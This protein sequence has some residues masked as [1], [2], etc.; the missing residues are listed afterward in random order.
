MTYPSSPGFGRQ[1]RNSSQT[2][3][4]GFVSNVLTHPKFASQSFGCRSLLCCCTLWNPNYWEWCCV[5]R[6]LNEEGTQQHYGKGKCYLHN[7][8]LH[9][10]ISVSTNR[11]TASSPCQRRLPFV[12]EFLMKCC[13]AMLA[14]MRS[15]FRFIRS[16]KIKPALN[17]VAVTEATLPLHL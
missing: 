16:V 12:R 5:F 1:C 2:Q 9:A 10:I 13:V 4:T 11:D 6:R 14:C 8:L 17:I 7:W 3:H 15:S